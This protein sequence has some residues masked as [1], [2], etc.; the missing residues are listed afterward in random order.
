MFGLW[1]WTLVLRKLHL[2]AGRAFDLFYYVH[3]PALPV[4]CWRCA[5][6]QHLSIGLLCGAVHDADCILCHCVSFCRGR[7]LWARLWWLI[8]P[9]CSCSCKQTVQVASLA[10][11]SCMPWQRRCMMVRLHALLTLRVV[12][13]ACVTVG[14]D[15]SCR[16]SAL[17]KKQRV[18]AQQVVNLT[19]CCTGTNTKT[20][21]AAHE[22]CCAVPL[23]S[24]HC[25][26]FFAHSLAVNLIV[27]RHVWRLLIATSHGMCAAA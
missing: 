9:C 4:G 12:E 22:C 11:T 19:P 8:Q 7:Y 21:Q 18:S 17:R 23:G 20:L 25:I 5:W 14:S 16:S 24:E 2:Y 3:R 26:N 10:S 27:L 15:G 1:P 6:L 13:V